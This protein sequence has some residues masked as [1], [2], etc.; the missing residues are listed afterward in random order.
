M[1]P[2]SPFDIDIGNEISRLSWKFPSAAA[3]VPLAVTYVIIGEPD[4]Y[5]VLS[6]F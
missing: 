6:L 2:L 1:L 5:P 3:V 4:T